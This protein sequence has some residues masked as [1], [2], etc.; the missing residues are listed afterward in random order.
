[1]NWRNEVRIDEPGWQKELFA[2]IRAQ[3]GCNKAQG[4]DLGTEQRL[5]STGNAYRGIYALLILMMAERFWL[6][7]I[8]SNV[9][10]SCEIRAVRLTRARKGMRNLISPLA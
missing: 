6:P 9:R 4:L 7:E 10:N 5:S 3:P 8:V 2:P 1:M